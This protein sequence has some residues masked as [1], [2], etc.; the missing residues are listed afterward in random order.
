MVCGIMPDQEEVRVPA[1]Y[2]LGPVTATFA[3][4]SL[5]AQRETAECIAFDETGS[6]GLAVN[7][8]VSWEDV[9]RRLPG[10]EPDFLVLYLAYTTIPPGLWAAPVPII[11]LAMDWN[12]LWSGYRH[13]LDRCDLVLT[14]SLGA[15]K[16]RCEGIHHVLPANLFG[17]QR[18]FADW[19]EPPRARDIDVLF[20]GN[21]SAPVQRERLPWLGRLA[22][23]SERWR[24]EIHTGVYGDD[25]RELLSRARIVFNRSIRGECNLRV[26]EAISAGAMLFQEEENREIRAYLQPGK[27]CILYNHANLESLLEYYL[28]H[29][30]QR[31]TIAEAARARIREFRF[32]TLWNGIVAQIEADWPTI[33]ERAEA[34]L[35]RHREWKPPPAGSPSEANGQTCVSELVART[36]QTLSSS[37]G[38]DPALSRD[39]AAALVERPTVAAVHNALGLVS[40]LANQRQGRLARAAT[41]AAAGYFQRA[42]ASE[43]D[44]LVAG[45]NLV[46]ALAALDQKTQAMEQARRVLTI[47]DQAGNQNLA[48]LTDPHFP[49][50]FDVFRVEWERAA[51]Q[52]A[53][54]PWA[55][56]RDKRQLIRWR[57]H[58][59]LADLTGDLHH[60][61]E[62]S[63]ARP[64]LPI[65]R[66]VLGCALAR[67]GRAADAVPH[68]RRALADNPLDLQAG[69]ALFQVLGDAGDG[70]GQR[71]LAAERRA[72]ARTGA[73]PSEP[74]ML[75]IPPVGDE[76]VSIIILCCNE[77][78][79]TRLCIESVLKHSRNPYELVIVDNGSSDGTAAYLDELTHHAGPERVTVIRNETNRGFAAGCNQAIAQAQGCYLVFLN[80]DTVVT[81][82]W[83]SGLVAGALHDWPNVGLVG[84]LS[85]YA[86]PPQHVV[87]EYPSLDA[88]E[89]FTAKLRRRNAGKALQVGRLTGF[90]LLVRRE[91]IEQIG[92]FDERYGTGFFE[93]DDFCVRAR[94]AGFRLLLATDIFIHHFGSR[95]FNG[96]HLD[97]RAQLQKNL[98]QF[99]Q[100]WGDEQARGYQLPKDPEP[101]R[102]IE[103]PQPNETADD[104]VAVSATGPTLP[105]GRPTVSL[106][107][108]VKNEEEN[109]R[110]C[111]Q[112]VADLVDEMIIVDT[113]STDRTKEIAAELGARVSDFP[114]RTA[115]RLPA[116]RACDTRPAIGSSGWMPMTGSTKPTAAS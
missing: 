63:I 48:P 70:L 36:W 38:S 56:H 20:V 49:P 115:S 74:W 19:R 27:E 91:V 81:S 101:D 62:A 9:R 61:Y 72:L 86:P 65:T 24:V 60:F 104:S 90:C 68:L 1:R 88:L 42:V 55:E 87:G 37:N 8:S 80:N 98:E 114:G 44:H 2:L 107:M 26:F 33:K 32:E 35:H 39:L 84:P 73:I 83:L 64:D 78:E 43:P 77:L 10:W 14:D 18:S 13:V 53:G 111:L 31:K 82:D 112:S 95:T 106:C 99:R 45:L 93:D 3:D 30:A 16:L 52:N 34:R 40:S 41:E 6:A 79:Y 15:D 46:E 109:L 108:I 113:G 94:Q 67:V 7:P 89:P 12:L 51:W 17:C 105:K 100:K 11:G 4:Q 97:G 76:L 103:P 69:R 71:R 57:L 21:T 29:E 47:L 23:V 116:T 54:Q 5:R 102:V 96:L 92:G 50:A 22:R 25:Y 28:E 66:A 75:N 59:L 58:T 110:P 85:N